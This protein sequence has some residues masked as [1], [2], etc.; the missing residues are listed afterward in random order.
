MRLILL[1]LFAAVVPEPST[2]TEPPA[3][4]EPAEEEPSVLLLEWPGGVGTQNPEKADHDLALFKED[5]WNRALACPRDQAGPSK[6][7]KGHVCRY[8]MT[9]EVDLGAHTLLA[10]ATQT[11]HEWD[12]MY[13]NADEVVLLWSGKKPEVMH[14]INQWGESVVDCRSTSHMRRYAV[15]ELADGGPRELCVETVREVGEGLFP[16]MD[17]GD[18]GVPWL[19]IGSKREFAAFSLDVKAKKLKRTPT[20]DAKCP[21]TGY[22]F[23]VETEVWDDGVS[24]VRKLQGDR[25]DFAQCPLEPSNSCFGIDEC[26]DSELGLASVVRFI[27]P[28]AVPWG[29]P[30]QRV[31]SGEM[32]AVRARV[33]LDDQPG[34]TLPAVTQGKPIKLRY[35]VRNWGAKPHSLWHSGFWTNHRVRVY[36]TDGEELPLTTRGQEVRK[37]FAPRG[38]RDKNVDWKL[39]PGKTDATE[40]AIDLREF[41][42]LSKP[43]TYLVQVEYEEEFRVLSNVLPLRITST[44]EDSTT[45]A[46]TTDRPLY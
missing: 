44:P 24:G 31:K 27:Q 22:R 17:L 36:D 38:K 35:E 13:G 4:P 37:A 19:P 15:V 9:G 40:G 11:S 12:G 32:L 1:L 2:G 29:A 20:L 10:A 5:E 39:A 33:S 3:A 6:D 18:A 43:G 34:K 7:G 45:K 14:T 21:R 30:A 8:R 26:P 41:F 25:L 28:R 16:L 23:F 42:A 46:K